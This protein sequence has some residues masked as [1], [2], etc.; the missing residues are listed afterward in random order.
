MTTKRGNS[1][2]FAVRKQS[3]PV[4]FAL[5]PSVCDLRI[6]Q[7]KGVYGWTACRPPAIVLGLANDVR[8]L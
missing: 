7:W 1:V 3:L 4:R 6:V 2:Y 8:W 5:F